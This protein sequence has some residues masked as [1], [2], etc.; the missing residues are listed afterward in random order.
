MIRRWHPKGQV[1][2]FVERPQGKGRGFQLALLAPKLPGAGGPLQGPSSKCTPR[3][4]PGQPP[5]LL[6]PVR[7][8]LAMPSPLPCSPA[9]QKTDRGGQGPRRAASALAFESAVGLPPGVFSGLRSFS[10]KR[11]G[12]SSGVTEQDTVPLTLVPPGTPEEPQT[13]ALV[14]SE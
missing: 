4:P 10:P 13:P 11:M 3:A 7:P 2:Q 12:G 1:T 6:A 14:R 9:W 5:A 8:A